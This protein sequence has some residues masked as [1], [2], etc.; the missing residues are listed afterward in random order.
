MR[1]RNMAERI[2]ILMQ[3]QN[4]LGLLKER[5]RLAR[6]LHDTVKQ[7]T[8]ATLMQVRTARNIL[9][10]DPAGDGQS[11]GAV[12]HL[13]EAEEMIK[14]S[15]QELGRMITELRPAALDGSGLPEALRQYVKAWTQHAQIPAEFQ[16]ENERALPLP[17]EEAILRV[18]QEALA[19]SSR[20]SQASQVQISLDYEPCAVR[21]VVADNGVGFDPHTIPP[22]SF[23]LRS[24]RE[25]VTALGGQITIDSAKD[26]GTTLRIMI[27]VLPSS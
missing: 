7:Q 14:T 24:M 27:P 23:G 9:E 22:Q 20:H 19:N 13:Q 4:E 17:V 16:V 26:R 6:E 21:L 3:S 8:F 5:N 25:R 12:Q 10:K 2:Q 11:T 1:L 18:A 15:Q